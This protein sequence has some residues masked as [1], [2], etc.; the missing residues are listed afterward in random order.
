M[1]TYEKIETLYQR[2]IEGT[3]KL[4]PGVYEDEHHRA[5]REFEEKYGMFGEKLRN[6][7]EE[8]G[9][10]HRLYTLHDVDEYKD[11]AEKYMKEARKIDQYRMECKDEAFQ[12]FSQWF[13]ALWD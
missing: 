7:E 2:D 5:Y 10:G 8:N 9:P 13:Y 1:K 11:I 4:M 12:M 6:P 3:K